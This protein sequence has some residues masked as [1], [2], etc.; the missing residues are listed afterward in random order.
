MLIRYNGQLGGE[1]VIEIR[2][3]CIIYEM[4]NKCIYIK[5]SNMLNKAQYYELLSN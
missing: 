3:C 2:E 4:S 5:G 1:K